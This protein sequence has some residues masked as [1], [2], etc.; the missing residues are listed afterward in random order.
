MKFSVA[1]K[2]C[3]PDGKDPA[4][5]GW[6]EEPDGPVGASTTVSGRPTRIR[7]VARG[8]SIYLHQSGYHSWLWQ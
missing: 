2:I 8:H 3:D 6:V 5:L 4:W 7:S 1:S